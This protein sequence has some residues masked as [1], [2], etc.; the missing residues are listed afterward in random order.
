[1]LQCY[2]SRSSKKYVN[3]KRHVLLHIS[4]SKRSFEIRPFI[5]LMKSCSLPRPKN[6]RS[7][8]VLS[9]KWWLK[10][11]PNFEFRKR[12]SEKYK[13][14][15][16]RRLKR[17]LIRRAHVYRIQISIICWK[18][19]KTINRVRVAQTHDPFCNDRANRLGILFWTTIHVYTMI[20]IITDN[21]CKIIHMIWHV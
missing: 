9:A 11:S 13:S 12:S 15:F 18:Y 1:M 14:C 20:L 3:S 19:K 7:L 8:S 2:P 6:P 16:K 4:V 5:R 10:N 21:M 17:R